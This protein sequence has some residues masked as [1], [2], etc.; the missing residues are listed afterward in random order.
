MAV[1]LR[2]DYL[3]QVRGWITVAVTPL[4]WI[5]GIPSRML[6]L[7][8]DALKS[9][10]ELEEELEQLRSRNLVLE[11]QVQKLADLRVQNLRL[12]ELLNSAED[13][14]EEVLAA[15]LVG[16][17]PNP[18]RQQIL[19]NRGER[20]GVVEG[21]SVLDSQG[22]LGQVIFVTPFSS[23]V[24]LITDLRHQIPV[25]LNRN[26]V[27]AIA[28]GTGQSDQLELKHIPNTEDIE[29]G[30]LLVS[31]GLG[32]RFPKGYPVGT[33]SLIERDPGRPFARILVTPT[34]R[35]SRS[36]YLLLVLP[37]AH[38]GQIEQALKESAH[39]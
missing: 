13:L 24:M 2:L 21:T 11:R 30:D 23:R 12:R 10:G 26:G 35:L 27:R 1:D 31:S 38:Q 8:D 39:E 25:E 33:V 4:Q 37:P 32:G 22:L 6:G 16:V 28:A 9:R 36:R 7:A 5:A 14:D 3:N 19:I 17:D 18:G 29:L 20:D 15:E 34:A